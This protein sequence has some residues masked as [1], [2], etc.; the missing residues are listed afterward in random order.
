MLRGEVAMT[1]S[2]PAVLSQ[3]QPEAQDSDVIDTRFGKVQL[4]RRQPIVFPTGLLGLPDKLQFCLTNFPSPKMARFKLLQSLE[5]L[6]LS[7]ITLPLDF[8]NPIIE[9]ADMEQAARDLDI[10]VDQLAT[11]LIVSVHREGGVT[12]LSVNARAPIFMHAAKRVAA[13]HVFSNT[14]YDIRRMITL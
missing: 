13:Q 14:K 12:R 5:D 4:Y 3:A 10:P 9:R 7:F 2:G 8:A 11:L 1:G 6:T